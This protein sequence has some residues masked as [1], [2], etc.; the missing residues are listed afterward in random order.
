MR[1]QEMLGLEWRRVDLQQGLVYLEAEH[2]KNRKRGSVPL[3][4]EARDAI[5]SRE[6]FRATSCPNSPWVFCHKN[7]SRIRNVRRSFQTACHNAGI[8]D[9]HPHDMRHTCAAWL[10]QKGVPIREVCDLLRH[11]DIRTT[12]GYAHLAP[13]NV[14]KAVTKIESMT[15]P[16]SHWSHTGAREKVRR[17]V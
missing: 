13:E 17:V 6:R 8:E 11:S 12:M 9:F 7:G 14:R 10:V 4:Q 16:S 3:N 15:V 5:V 1:K 2:Q